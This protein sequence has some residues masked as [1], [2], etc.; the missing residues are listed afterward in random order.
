MIHIC[1]FLF[2]AHVLD[3]NNENE[4]KKKNFTD[5]IYGVSTKELFSLL[6]ILFIF[7]SKIEYSEEFINL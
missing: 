3:L 6:I 2:N 5:D 4:S 1:L 7:D